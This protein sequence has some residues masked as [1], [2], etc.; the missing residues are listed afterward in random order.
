MKIFEITALSR[1]GHHSIKNWIIKNHIGF[2]IGWDYKFTVATNTHFYHLGEANHD[3]P[4]SLKYIKENNSTIDFLLCCYEDTFWDYTILDSRQV[5]MGPYNLNLQNELNFDHVG[6]VVFIRDFYNNLS[7]RLKSN[8]KQIFTKW[9][10]DKPHLFNV[11]EKFIERWKNLAR[12][13]VNNQ[14][15]YLKFEDWLT[16]QEIR[17]NFLFENFGL[18]DRYKLTKIQGTQSSFGD[19]ENVD[20]RFEGLVIPDETL[21]LISK[22]SELHYLIG[23]LGYEYKKF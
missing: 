16:N 11:G 14:V 13:A 2:Q 17:E 21:D 7:S 8:E 3:I 12:A 20:K 1:S 5:F 15:S 23:A 6:K 18:K 19:I 22:D 9:N 4:L 10:E